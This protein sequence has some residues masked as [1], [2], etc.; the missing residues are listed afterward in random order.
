[1]ARQASESASGSYPGHSISMRL[2]SSPAVQG[3]QA[4][5]LSDSNIPVAA[6]LPQ[7]SAL[8]V[9][10][11]LLFAA[12]LFGAVGALLYIAFGEQFSRRAADPAA[13]AAGSSRAAESKTVAPGSA[14][15]ATGSAAGTAP[16]P[17][18]AAPATTGSEGAGRPDAVSSAER[19]RV[20]PAG[21]VEATQDRKPSDN[22]HKQ[23]TTRSNQTKRTPVAAV[24]DSGPGLVKQ[25]KELERAG[26]WDDARAV[27]QRLERVRGY[28]SEALYRQAWAAFQANDTA[29]ASKLAQQAGGE[30]GA[31]QTPA[32]FLYGDALYRQGEYARAK[33]YYLSLRGKVHGDDHATAT[34]KV[35]ACNRALNLPETDGIKD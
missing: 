31:Y 25:A 18:T 9:V 34:K 20:K 24:E 7:R 2:Q 30:A 1:M 14:S 22:S 35:V 23:R 17:V 32:K 6:P 19:I 26:R 15:P 13:V 10:G 29:G 5:A 33:E 27:Y 28:H 12:V 16:A 3:L 21:D 11:W 8:N 4:P